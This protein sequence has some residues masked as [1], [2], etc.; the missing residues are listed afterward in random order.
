MMDERACV[1]GTEG[2][3]VSADGPILFT[4]FFYSATLSGRWMGRLR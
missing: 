3:R 4:I 1:E 2:V